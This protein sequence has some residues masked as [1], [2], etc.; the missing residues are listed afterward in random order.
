LTDTGLKALHEWARTPVGF[1]PLKSEALI[2]LLIGDLVGEQITRESMATLRDDI[3]DIEQRLDDAERRATALPHR[4]KYLRMAIDFMRNLL[5]LH[6]E[7]VDQVERELSSD[8]T[9][10]TSP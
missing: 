10:E 3:S 1:T 2:R 5:E 9:V 7:L 8:Q 6:L 4:E